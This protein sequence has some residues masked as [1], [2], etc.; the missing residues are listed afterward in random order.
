MLVSGSNAPPGHCAAP[1]PLGF[2]MVPSGRGH[3]LTE[4]GVN[5]GPMR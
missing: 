2:M 1:S 4:G 3:L 5:N